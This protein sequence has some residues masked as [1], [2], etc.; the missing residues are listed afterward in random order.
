MLSLEK[1]KI[2]VVYKWG[3]TPS[4]KCVYCPCASDTAE[5][6]DL[7][8]IL[9]GPVREDLPGDNLE[10]ASVLQEAEDMFR[11]FYRMVEEI[12]TLKEVEECARQAAEAAAPQG[13]ER[14]CHSATAE[15]SELPPTTA[16]FYTFL[17]HHGWDDD[18]GIERE[19]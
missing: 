17:W 7:P 8:E 3:R 2:S 16:F 12:F 9:C 18:H 11:L 1:L 13:T 19:V 15:P 4:P 14:R 10:R 6:S 5:A